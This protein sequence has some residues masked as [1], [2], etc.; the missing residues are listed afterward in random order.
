MRKAIFTTTDSELR[1]R[2][3]HTECT[4]LH[5]LDPKEYDRE[6]VGLMYKVKLF[7]GNVIDAFE[8]ELN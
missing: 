2:Y 5:E 1:G 7:D 3:D 8:D 6:D 4:V